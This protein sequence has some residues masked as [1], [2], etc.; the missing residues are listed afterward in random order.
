MKISKFKL[1]LSVLILNAGWSPGFSVA[2]AALNIQVVQKEDVEQYVLG[3]F[4]TEEVKTALQTEGTIAHVMVQKLKKFPLFTFIP[5]NHP[6]QR[7][8]FTSYYRLLAL[9]HDQY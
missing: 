4:Q 8:N 2:H 7:L 9:R 6:A 5:N 1:L 3:L